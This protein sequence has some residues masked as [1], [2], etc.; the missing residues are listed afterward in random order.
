[1]P[2]AFTPTRDGLNDVFKASHE[3]IIEIHLRIYNKYGSLVF[4]SYD[5]DAQWDGTF[6]NDPLPQDTYLYVIEYV[7]ESGVSRTEQGKFTLLR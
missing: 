6:N 7:A 2:T 3:N 1:M 4:E 5:L